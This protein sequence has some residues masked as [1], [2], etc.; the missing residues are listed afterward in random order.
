MSQESD[1]T[2]ITMSGKEQEVN[3]VHL[4]IGDGGRVTAAYSLDPH[5]TERVR[6]VTYAFAYCAPQD[7]FLKKVGRA[8][9]GGRLR[10]NHGPHNE[11]YG[12]FEENIQINPEEGIYKQIAG[13]LY[14]RAISLA[15]QRNFPSWKKILE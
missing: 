5:R 14:D 2:T 7:T 3:Y 9:A 13:V 1:R 10:S 4:T 11:G 6:T 8:K 12:P 15:K